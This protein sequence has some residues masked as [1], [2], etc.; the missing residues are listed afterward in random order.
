MNGGRAKWEAEGRP[1]TRDVPTYPATSYTAKEPDPAIRAF[2][3]DVLDPGQVRRAGAWST[4]AR[5]R[6]TPAR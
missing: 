4:S 6:S 3:D 1:Y 5:R 2:R